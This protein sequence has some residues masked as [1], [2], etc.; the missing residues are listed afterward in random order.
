MGLFDKLTGQ[1]DVALT[2]QAGLL[3]AAITMVA[4]DGDVDD[5]EIAVI[6]RLDGT[7]STTAW[8]AALKT[9][10]MKSQSECISLAT[11]AMSQVQRHVTMANLV[12]IAMADGELAGAE[13]Q[14][15]QAY[16]SA[17]G[18]SEGEVGKIVDVIAVKNNKEAF[19]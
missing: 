12:D 11:S 2:P 16:V 1:R 17:F 10:K 9:Y 4:A 5:D 14:L 8:E 7:S 18:I 3:L 6:R 19:M 13:K 15:L